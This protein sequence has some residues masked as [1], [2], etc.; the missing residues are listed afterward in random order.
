[1]PSWQIPIWDINS[2][3]WGSLNFHCSLDAQGLDTQGLDTQ[4][5]TLLSLEHQFT[6]TAAGAACF[7][8]ALVVC[9]NYWMVFHLSR[10][11]TTVQWCLQTQILIGMQC[12][13]YTWAFFAMEWNKT[14]QS[15]GLTG[16]YCRVHCY[17]NNSERWIFQNTALI[18]LLQAPSKDHFIEWLLGF[19]FKI[20]DDNGIPELVPGLE[21]FS[22]IFLDFWWG[23]CFLL[24]FC[25]VDYIK[26]PGH[27]QK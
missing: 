16:L 10:N 9:F 20:N 18:H 19:V 12:N 17:H 27:E 4:G 1:M 26:H 11:I 7:C 25:S 13:K 8:G 24:Y 6:V 5:W 22:T 21:I 15:F 14:L 3:S 2:N 23:F